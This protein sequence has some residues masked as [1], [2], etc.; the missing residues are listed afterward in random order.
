[1]YRYITIL[2]PGVQYRHI[3]I[4]RKTYKAISTYRYTSIPTLGGFNLMR[5]VNILEWIWNFLQYNTL[6][7]ENPFVPRKKAG[8]QMQP[9]RKEVL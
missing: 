8:H 2:K 5:K 9:A 7:T 4:Q 1:M 3:T 6:S